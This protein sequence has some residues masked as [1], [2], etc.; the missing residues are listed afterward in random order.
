MLV[1]VAVPIFEAM[2]LP[3][4]TEANEIFIAIFVRIHGDGGNNGL[5]QLKCLGVSN[6]LS[7]FS[8]AKQL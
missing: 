1:A 8:P 5:V 2:Q 7:I 4:F 3:V 6:Q